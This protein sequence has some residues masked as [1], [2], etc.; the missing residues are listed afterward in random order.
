MYKQRRCNRTACNGRP[1]EPS[2]Q[3][4]PPPP[5]PTHYAGPGQSPASNVNTLGEWTRTIS[6]INGQL[7]ATQSN[8]EHPVLQD[9]PIPGGSVK[10]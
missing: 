10:N 7:A 9:D 4:T 2:Q 3:A 5:S 6:G 1:R 8:S